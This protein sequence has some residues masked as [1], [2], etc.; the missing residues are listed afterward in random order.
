MSQDQETLYC[1]LRRKEKKGA[2]IWGTGNCHS[3]ADATW[4]LSGTVPLHDSDEYWYRKL[5]NRQDNVNIARYGKGRVRVHSRQCPGTIY[6]DMRSF[7]RI[8]MVCDCPDRAS[9]VRKKGVYTEVQVQVDRLFYHVSREYYN[10]QHI[11]V[12]LKWAHINR[13]FWN[14][15][16]KRAAKK[17]A[18]SS[19][20]RHEPFRVWVETGGRNRHKVFNGKSSSP[21]S[22]V[23]CNL[24]ILII[25]VPCCQ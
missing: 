23:S 19:S 25:T 1:A 5:G 24:G 2:W 21:P 10:Q 6:H 8:D 7:I 12:G 9:E 17:S 18:S 14:L 16:T 3:A 4:T 20:I 15:A 22:L 13:M 11:Q